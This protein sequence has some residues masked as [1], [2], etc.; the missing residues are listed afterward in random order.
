MKRFLSF[1]LI[2]TFLHT[3]LSGVGI[4][5]NLAKAEGIKGFNCSKTDDEGNV[6]QSSC[7]F[8]ATDEDGENIKDGWDVTFQHLTLYTVVINGVTKTCK[9]Y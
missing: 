5:L 7:T 3:S 9:M 4:H 1:V 8:D 6:D 2:L